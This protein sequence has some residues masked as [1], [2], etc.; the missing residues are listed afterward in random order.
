MCRTRGKT[1]SREVLDEER[2]APLSRFLP[3]DRQKRS[4]LPIARP[5]ASNAGHVE[6]RRRKVDAQRHLPGSR[7]GGNHAWVANEQRNADGLFIG[8]PSLLVETVL[9]VEVPMV[10]GEHDDGVVQ[11]RPCARASPECVQ[12]CRRHPA[13]SRGAP[14]CPRPASRYRDPS[15]GVRQSDGGGPACRA[16]AGRRSPVAASLCPHIAATVA[17]GGNEPTWLAGHRGQAPVISLH[18]VGVDGFVRQVHEERLFRR[19]T[20]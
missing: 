19:T 18:Q 6:Q 5:S 4:A 17:I 15:A 10:A 11:N 12:G 13:A 8:E 1:V 7:T 2:R 20:R 3:E 16:A 9:S 14:G